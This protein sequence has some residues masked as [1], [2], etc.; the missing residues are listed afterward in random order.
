MFNSF[1]STSY[2]L[3]FESIPRFKLLAQDAFIGN[4]NPSISSANQL[5]IGT[6]INSSK[7]KT[8]KNSTTWRLFIFYKFFCAIFH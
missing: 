3:A 4:K 6:Q 1:T 5:Q 7:N 8:G 2:L